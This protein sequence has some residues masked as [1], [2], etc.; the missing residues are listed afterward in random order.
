MHFL[1]V[2]QIK[3]NHQKEA[4]GGGG[5]VFFSLAH[6]GRGGGLTVWPLGGLEVNIGSQ[7]QNDDTQL[8]DIKFII[9]SY[10]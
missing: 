8:P 2:E 7:L 10:Y 9:I 1:L 5:S 4:G 3:D 6:T